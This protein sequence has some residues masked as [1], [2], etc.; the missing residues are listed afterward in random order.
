MEPNA[1]KNKTRTEMIFVFP[2]P[3]WVWRVESQATVWL[4]AC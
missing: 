1:F 3:S 4:W 2:H